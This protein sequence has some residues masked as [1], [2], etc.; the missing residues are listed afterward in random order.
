AAVTERTKAIL[1]GY[2]SNPTGA[3]MP[4][5]VLEDVVAF[6]R[7]HNLYIVS[8]EIYDR[9][10]YDGD[11]TC[12]A[13][14]PGAR[15]RTVTLNG[16]SKA[17]AMTGWR[18]GYACAPAPILAA[19]VKVHAYTNMCISTVAQRAAIEALHTAE[20]AVEEMARQ[21]NQRR[22][23]IVNGLNKVGLACHMPQGAFYAFPSIVGT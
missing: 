18:V 20:P 15:E 4:R 21:Y 23:L 8:D 22:R 10:T 9:L 19:M 2:P 5:A 13:S 1:L 17:Y 16:F 3:A 11:H 6:A 14:L 7:R 12:V